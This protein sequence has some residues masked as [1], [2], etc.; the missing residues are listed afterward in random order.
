MGVI[1]GGAGAV[2]TAT[3][4]A[5]D[6]AA[7]G[8][9]ALAALSVGAGDAVVGISA[10]GRTPY[11]LAAV[12]FARKRG[13]LTIGLACNAGSEL[14][15]AVEHPIEVVVGPEFIAGSTRLKAGTA[16]KLV[17]NMLSTLTMVRLGKT[18]GN[19][20][21]DVRVTNEKLRDRAIRIVAQAAGVGHAEAEAA[22]RE[23]ADDA[24]V[25]V[26][27]LRSGR[28]RRCGAGEAR[29]R[30]RQPPPRA[31]RVTRPCG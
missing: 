12:G 31:R 24:K 7:A 14:S 21:V 6:D 19:L 5:E 29:R 11:V 1:A 4:S 3:E 18:Y 23:A 20:M 30:R 8:A 10:S 17:L 22:L 28:E 2:D 9:A 27:M 15:A 25:A 13:A 16:Q 26:T